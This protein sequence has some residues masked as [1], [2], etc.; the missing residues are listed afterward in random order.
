MFR[1]PT[2]HRNIRILHNRMHVIPLGNWALEPESEMLVFIFSYTI[3]CY[4][5]LYYIPDYSMY[6]IRVQCRLGSTGNIGRRASRAGGPGYICMVDDRTP[7][8]L[9]ISNYNTQT[10]GMMVV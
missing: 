7:A 4:T 8:W 3:R 2:D 10:L 5:V 1:A 6:P 9:S